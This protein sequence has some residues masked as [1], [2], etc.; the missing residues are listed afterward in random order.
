MIVLCLTELAVVIGAER[1]T[2]AVAAKGR[3]MCHA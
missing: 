3:G 1:V 2:E